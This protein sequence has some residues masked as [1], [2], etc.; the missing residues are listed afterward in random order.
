MTVA[1]FSEMP[2]M[3]NKHLRMVPMDMLAPFE[4][5]AIRNHGQTL[6]R[7]AERGGM[8]SSEILAVLEG[9][10]WGEVKSCEANDL[11]LKRRADAFSKNKGLAQ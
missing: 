4:A 7:L 9:R 5:Q 10:K 11:L 2:V 6:N 8:S 3:H 1:K